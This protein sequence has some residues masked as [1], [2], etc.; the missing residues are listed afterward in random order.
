VRKACVL[1]LFALSVASGD[2]AADDRAP[3]RVCVASFVTTPASARGPVTADELAD[4]LAL[5]PS[6]A[7]VDR[8]RVRGVE[9]D[10]AWT[11]PRDD[12][13]ALAELG[14][15][16]GATLVVGGKLDG[17]RAHVVYVTV[18]RG[19]VESADPTVGKAR[20]DVTAA[21]IAAD[22]L[23]R[24]ALEPPAL[25]R[26]AIAATDGDDRAFALYTDGREA[27]FGAR[28]P[29]RAIAGLVAATKAAPG[30]ARAHAVLARARLAKHDLDG[31]RAAAEAAMRA[32]GGLREAR[33]A[34]ARALDESERV[35]EAI[36]AYREALAVAP[37]D[38]TAATNLGRLLV[39]KKRDPAAGL[40]LF[41]R[42]VESEPTL[43]IARVNRGLAALTLGRVDE[44]V[45]I[46]EPLAREHPTEPH[47]ALPAATA[48]RR[49]RRPA[50][51]EAIARAVLDAIPKQV[52]ARF[53]LALA[54]SDEGRHK[55]ALAIVEDAAVAAEPRVR[56][57]RGRVLMHMGD[58][59]GAARALDEIAASA[60]GKDA[61]DAK[62]ARAVV[63]LRRGKASEARAILSRLV[64]E[65]PTDAEA[66]H[67]LAV[68][69]EAG[70][71][72]AS[73]RE[74]YRRAHE[75]MPSMSAAAVGLARLLL[76]TDA[77]QAAAVCDRA[78]AASTS[79]SGDDL[80][81]L[82]MLRGL[83][84]WRSGKPADAVDDLR[85]AADA[86]R[87]E[88][89]AADA[90]AALAEALLAAGRPADARTEAA[91]A[92]ALPSLSPDRRPR[93]TRLTE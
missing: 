29:E 92:L 53:E 33:L 81:R 44:A 91:R 8:D 60:K 86:A 52:E 35:D 84:R 88:P 7:V 1:A 39:F 30:L 25:A 76:T 2:A 4:R 54:L 68:A 23:A 48:L 57:A 36:A 87:S 34:R 61:R 62:L 63:E 82:R 74:A 56:V 27:L 58:L 6:L 21:A 10:L 49:A 80:A 89:L 77:A 55:D 26:A 72:S 14:R 12:P 13:Q 38:A 50:R 11:A 65:D 75:S 19:A 59:D 47:L 64:D 78:L 17:A 16:L 18:D 51:A 46:L 67:D 42:A 32:G 69:A 79:T 85:A 37:H 20:A 70:G 9:R 93:L 15:R 73:A 22:L 66:Q 71:D 41:E 5:V 3:V 28:D 31:A 40:A 43:V 24:R 45:A 83:A 90:R